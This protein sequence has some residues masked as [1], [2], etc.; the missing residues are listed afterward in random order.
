MRHLFLPGAPA[1]E[2]MRRWMA[3]WGPPDAG[4]Y[5]AVA[6][7]DDVTQVVC[8][9]SGR[10]LPCPGIERCPYCTTQAEVHFMGFLP[11]VV[12]HPI[13]DHCVLRLTPHAA[14][15]LLRIRE[16]QDGHLR[17][18]RLKLYRRSKSQ[19]ARVRVEADGQCNKK[20]LDAGWDV[21]P[22]LR[23]LWGCGEHYPLWL[24]WQ[25]WLDTM[26]IVDVSGAEPQ[27]GGEA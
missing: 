8:H 25:A 21:L 18:T 17:G 14:D 11:A 15:D 7:C 16:A 23:R 2:G 12:A 19:K 13:H 1:P 6:L 26:E 9:W 5:S 20:T 22:H 10:L 27:K 4:P 3:L 24:S